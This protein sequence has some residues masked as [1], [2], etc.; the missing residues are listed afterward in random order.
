MKII[1]NN[2]HDSHTKKE[3]LITNHKRTAQPKATV[4]K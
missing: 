3:L 2:V 4:V 1:D